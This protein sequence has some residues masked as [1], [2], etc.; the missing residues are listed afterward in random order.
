MQ[1]SISR[2]RLEVLHVGVNRHVNFGTAD[3]ARFLHYMQ[4]LKVP[5]L[6]YPDKC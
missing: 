4:N 5:V 6:K 3:M 1:D 2:E